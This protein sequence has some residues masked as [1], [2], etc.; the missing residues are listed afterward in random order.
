MDTHLG[1]GGGRGVVLVNC[2]KIP[3]MNNLRGK[4]FILTDGFGLRSAGSIAFSVK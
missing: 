3:K 4:R 2:G 1:H